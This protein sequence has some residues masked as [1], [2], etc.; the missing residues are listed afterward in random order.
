M[1]VI[2]RRKI[3]EY[4]RH[5]RVRYSTK[6]IVFIQVGTYK[7]KFIGGVSAVHTVLKKVSKPAGETPNNVGAS[8]IL[9]N[10]LI[11]R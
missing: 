7:Y 9:D 5:T 2:K 3:T 6:K 1:V 4:N 10:E 11:I 8:K